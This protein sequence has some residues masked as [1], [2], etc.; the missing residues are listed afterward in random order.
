M[1]SLL[2]NKHILV[3]GGNGYI[4]RNFVI[5]SLEEGWYLTLLG[6]S[7]P[8]Q[9]DRIR[10]ISWRIGQSV[11]MDF[12]R[13]K[14]GWP[15][16]DILVHLAHDWECKNEEDEDINLIGSEILFSQVRLLGVKRIIFASSISARNDSLN[17]YGRTKSKI[18]K[19]LIN[20]NEIS[21]RIGLVYGGIEKGQWGALCRLVKLSPLIPMLDS[22]KLVQ[23]IKID[24][25]G[26]GLVRLCVL[27]NPKSNFY[28]LGSSEP[29]EFG[30]FLITLSNF[31]FNRN[32]YI[33]SIP[34]KIILPFIYILSKIKFISK[35][36]KERILG[37]VGLTILENKKN[38]LELDLHL[39][40]LESGLVSDKINRRLLLE[41]GQILLNYI[42]NRKPNNESLKIYVRSVV[43]WSNGLPIKL[44]P[45][46]YLPQLLRLFEPL[47]KTSISYPTENRLKN[48]LYLSTLISDV[49]EGSKDIY[50]YKKDRRIVVLLRL[51]GIFLV[52]LMVFP[53][54]FFLGKLY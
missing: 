35:F 8:E 15:D 24:E 31:R 52:E 46:K 33:V 32:L 3:T 45:V 50:R 22:A 7:F 14:I 18:E 5:K 40:T 26:T 36:N 19:M 53:F 39:Q 23:P 1:Y 4:G 20:P 17:R 38:L 48:R 9:S 21:A 29:L 37:L 12:I 27:L 28:A 42:L 54:R 47:H 25:V 43:K 10:F 6:N 34:S 44:P 16:A 51:F 13:G 11:S 2:K 41:E 49:G 30:K